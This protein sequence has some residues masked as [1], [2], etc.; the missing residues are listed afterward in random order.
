MFRNLTM[1]GL[2]LG[3]HS[4]EPTITFL[5]CP[6]T[7]LHIALQRENP[8]SFLVHFH[9][10][11]RNMA[12]TNAFVRIKTQVKESQDHAKIHLSLKEVTINSKD[13]TWA[14]YFHAPRFPNVGPD[15]M[16]SEKVTY[17]IE[18]GELAEDKIDEYKVVD[19]FAWR[20]RNEKMATGSETNPIWIPILKRTIEFEGG[21][22]KIRTT[23]LASFTFIKWTNIRF[24]I[25]KVL[26]GPKNAVAT[27]ERQK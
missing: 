17:Q 21:K 7:N 18:I 8:Q 10:R 2:L 13:E 25:V 16:D 3:Y 15:K 20:I 26:Q 23:Q 6:D 12:G 9:L 24:N 1:M 22:F 5:P 19:A 27:A 14:F 4:D 11:F